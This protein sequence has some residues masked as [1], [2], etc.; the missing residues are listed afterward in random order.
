MVNTTAIY[1]ISTT[2]SS[3]DDDWIFWS[4]GTTT[5]IVYLALNVILMI[6]VSLIAYYRLRDDKKTSYLK[7][8]WYQKD[9]YLPFLA[10]LYD[11][12]T[13]I[14]VLVVFGNLAFDGN[15]YQNV[16]MKVIFFTALGIIIF[17]RFMLLM[18][19]NKIC[20]LLNIILI[21]TDLHIYKSLFKSIYLGYKQASSTQRINELVESIFESLPQVYCYKKHFI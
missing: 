21:I 2:I 1:S 4:F 19:T 6:I 11:T 18:I 10:S 12:T 8:V 14:A 20:N 16:N 5:L 7:L 13:D 17:Y 15:D 3:E 9:I